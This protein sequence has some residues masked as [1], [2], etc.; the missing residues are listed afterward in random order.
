MQCVQPL[1]ERYLSREQYNSRNQRFRLGDLRNVNQHDNFYTIESDKAIIEERPWKSDKKY[2][3]K[4]YISMVA[5]LKMTLHAVS[6]GNI[7][8]MGMITGKIIANA[9]VVMDVYAL[10]VEGTETR[11]N[12]Q[13]EGYEY[14]VRYLENSKRAGKSENIV[15]WYHSHPGYGCWLS[16]ID[17]ATQSLN[18]N[19]QDPYL[20][21][22]IDPIRTTEQGYV[23]IGA[24]RTF[25]EDTRPEHG[26]GPVSSAQ[27]RSQARD[28][29]VHHGRYYSLAVEFFKS[30]MDT[31]LVKLFQNSSWMSQLVGLSTANR[32]QREETAQAA[33]EL[34]TS[35]QKRK[36]P[37]LSGFEVSLAK[38]FD[39]VFEEIVS[40]K[41]NQGKDSRRRLSNTSLLSDA[42]LT[43]S[44]DDA[45]SSS[46][47][48]DPPC[49]NTDLDRLD[50]S[51]TA[52]DDAVS[53]DSALTTPCRRDKDAIN[54]STES[55]R[56]DSGFLNPG[57]RPK[58]ALPRDLPDDPAG[59]AKNTDQALLNISILANRIGLDSLQDYIATTTKELIFL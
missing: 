24:F 57:P 29:G 8:V 23:E 54:S 33:F 48:D 15:G 53:M 50:I 51:D 55:S 32:L 22:V 37:Q 6:G 2:F 20:A 52:N 43:K 19:F 39:L 9:I 38:K 42:A 34:V 59:E 44:M 25:P 56:R 21:I 3:S 30:S 10:P 47:L 4:V 28:F 12:A 36:V 40:M 14:M 7:E 41:L 45:D 11:V 35:L 31:E 58:S 26:S 18:Q 46:D 13:A 16:G 5:L 1:Y 49:K 17:V 27:R